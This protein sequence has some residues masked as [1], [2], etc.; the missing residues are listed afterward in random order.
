MELS[1]IWAQMMNIS[2]KKITKEAFNKIR[3]PKNITDLFFSLSIQIEFR[4]EKVKCVGFIF[5]MSGFGAKLHND[6]VFH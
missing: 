5:L 6:A 3:F 2:V 4:K 1:Q